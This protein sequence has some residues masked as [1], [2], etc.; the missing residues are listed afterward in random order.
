MTLLAGVIGASISLIV[1][2]SAMRPAWLT[3]V[4]ASHTEWA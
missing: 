4:Y 2:L 3:G 1:I